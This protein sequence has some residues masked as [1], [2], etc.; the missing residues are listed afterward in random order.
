MKSGKTIT[1]KANVFSDL[2]YNITHTATNRPQGDLVGWS[3]NMKHFRLGKTIE[4]SSLDKQKPI[5]LMP[6]VGF[7]PTTSMSLSGN[8]IPRLTHHLDH[9]ATEDKSQCGLPGKQAHKSVD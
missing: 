1:H 2:F 9:S 8:V 7:E 3:I 4:M 6:V 5:L